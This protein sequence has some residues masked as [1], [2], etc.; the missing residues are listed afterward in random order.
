MSE[1]KDEGEEGGVGGER[2]VGRRGRGIKGRRRKGRCVTSD[3]CIFLLRRRNER[4]W[5]KRWV[6]FNG[7][8]L[9]YFRNKQD[10]DNLCLNTVDLEK[11]IDVKRVQDVSEEG[12]KEGGREACPWI[13]YGN[14]HSEEACPVFV[15]LL[16][17]SFIVLHGHFQKQVFMLWLL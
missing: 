3:V 2:R 16:Q 12:G 10:K 15:A 7:W 17:R 8:E 11:M 13:L 5:Q 4:P 9:K 6:I 1:G 14:L